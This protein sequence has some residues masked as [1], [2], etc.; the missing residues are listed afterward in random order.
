MAQD[1]LLKTVDVREVYM[2]NI[3]TANYEIYRHRNVIEYYPV[4]VLAD[5]LDQVLVN[6]VQKDIELATERINLKLLMNTLSNGDYVLLDGEYHRIN[7]FGD[8]YQCTENGSF[9]IG[10]S[11]FGSYSGGFKWI[12]NAPID[13]LELT[14]E[15]RMGHFWI[16]S[17]DD[18]KG[19]N[20]VHF[21]GLFKVWKPKQLINIPLGA[22]VQKTS[23]AV[24]KIKKQN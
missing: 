3:H 18:A 19:H 7:K 1:Q 10:S 23:S 21:E 14:E 20:S 17:N 8:R 12:P 2:N 11:G 5:V 4:T 15:R 22:D 24:I 6:K 13:S 9:H 16:F